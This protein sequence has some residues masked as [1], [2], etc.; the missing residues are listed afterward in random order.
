[1]RKL[2]EGHGVKG[3]KREESTPL[4]EQGEGVGRW[5][6]IRLLV[7]LLLPQPLRLLWL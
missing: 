7:L 5:R 6:V 1:L 2:P 3:G 4:A